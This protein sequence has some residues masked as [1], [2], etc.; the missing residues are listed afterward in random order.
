MRR[1]TKQTSGAE[2]RGSHGRDTRAI[3]SARARTSSMAGPA[4]RSRRAPIDR[5]S[6]P[7]QRQTQDSLSR[8]ALVWCGSNAASV[9]STG[10]VA[11][12]GS[13]HELE[14]EL[15]EVRSSSA[16]SLSRA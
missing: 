12:C 10:A 14:L 7:C 16:N 8:L 15:G 1:P 3:A 6:H 5:P 2:G 13:S 9:T 11:F 4:A